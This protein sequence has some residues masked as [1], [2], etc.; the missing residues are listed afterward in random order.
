METR[1]ITTQLRHRSWMEDYARQQESGLTVRE[2]CAQ[3]GIT[4]KTFYYRLRVLRKEACAFMKSNAESTCVDATATNF[5]K[6]DIPKEESVQ[7][8]IKIK[9]SEAEIDISPD[10]NTEHVKL[11]L[12]AIAHA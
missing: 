5:V 12:E 9:L 6:V 4:Q 11:V 3:S 1:L 7:S 2:W 10:S 8:G